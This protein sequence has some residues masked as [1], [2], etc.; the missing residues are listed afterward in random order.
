M[1]IL[2]LYRCLSD[3][4]RLRLLHLLGLGPLCV[5][6]FQEILKL[7]QTAISKHLAYLR[8][9]G[10]VRVRRQGQWRIYHLPEPLPEELGLQLQALQ[11]CVKK[12]PVFRTDLKRL[13]ETEAG[14]DWAVPVVTKAKRKKA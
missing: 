11:E 13:K 14:C 8:I 6:H 9:R 5:C 3:E 4:T 10:V 1:K 2:T 12:H 7:P